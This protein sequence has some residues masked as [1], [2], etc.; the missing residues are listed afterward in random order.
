[1]LAA[2]RQRHP[3]QLVWREAFLARLAGGT[4]LHHALVQG[5]DATEALMKAWR[6]DAARFERETAVD[7]L[8]R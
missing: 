2:I 4:A 5:I 6:D 7:R 1:M 8:Y 3:L